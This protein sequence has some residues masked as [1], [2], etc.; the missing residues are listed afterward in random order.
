M[1]ERFYNAD[2]L[3]DV[4]KCMLEGIA[5]PDIKAIGGE[6]WFP[7]ETTMEEDLAGGDYWGMATG[8]ISGN[9]YAYGCCSEW[10][11]LRSV[12]LHRP[13]NE[14]DDFDFDKVRFRAPVDSVKFRAQHDALAQYY[15]DHDIEVIYAE[16]GRADRP[17]SVFCRD[18]LFMT[19]EG[20]IITRLCMPERR[21]EERFVAAACA[22]AGVPIVKTIAGD[23]I[24]EGANAMWVDR[25]SCILSISV[26]ANRSGFEQMEHEL[27]RQGVNDIIPMQIPYGHA[28]IDGLMTFP[29]EDICLIHACQVPYEVV[30]RVKKKG[31]HILET[32]S[33][34]ET[35]YGYATNV[36]AIDNGHVVTSNLAPRTV[37]LLEKHGV[38]VDVLDFSE[39]NK[40]RGSVHCMTAF[41][42]RDMS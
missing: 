1:D 35:K 33:L 16:G 27:R 41:L 26:R 39:L 29:S 5:L 21:G 34:T 17:N 10:Q 18:K 38:R 40:G 7:E 25:H 8:P 4:D 3:I 20:A 24:Y 14:V 30:D 13:A 31:Y 42:S 12:L 6:R 11:K 22:K 19:P 15:R 36:V 2:G 9:R 28:H 32:P 37:E 23:S